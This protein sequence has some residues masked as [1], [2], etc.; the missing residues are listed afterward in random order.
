[1]APA[2]VVFDEA[3][4]SREL[5]AFVNALL[6]DGGLEGKPSE[7]TYAQPQARPPNLATETVGVL[8]SVFLDSF[9]KFAAC[10]INR[11]SE[12]AAV[13]GVLNRNVLNQKSV[14]SGLKRPRNNA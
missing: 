9:G 14:N 6:T 7:T 5:T 13:D 8:L 12:R 3:M 4:M 2:A 11:H 1:M 10:V